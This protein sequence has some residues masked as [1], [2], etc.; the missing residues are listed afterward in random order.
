MATIAGGVVI[1][2]KPTPPAPGAA[3]DSD[4][5]KQR[6]YPVIITCDRAVDAYKKEFIVLTGHLVFK[7]TI[8]KDN[9]KMVERTL[10]AEHAEYDG[11]ANKLHL[12]TPVN[13]YDSEGR[14]FDFTADVFVGTKEREE[15]LST[16][17][18]TTI[19]FNAD[20]TSGDDPAADDKGASPPP[21]K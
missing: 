10:T 17:G 3:D 4:T 21:S 7:Q 11:K 16:P 20:D 12:F 5:A 18:R 19:H 6:K 15:T 2:L 1:T 13:S 14:T 8:L 9:G